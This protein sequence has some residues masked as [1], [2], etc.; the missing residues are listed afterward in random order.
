MITKIKNHTTAIKTKSVT[1]YK[2]VVTSASWKERRDDKIAV[3][4]I[5]Q[6]NLSFGL[7]CKKIQKNYSSLKHKHLIYTGMYICVHV[8]VHLCMCTCNMFKIYTRV[9]HKLKKYF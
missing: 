8:C 1:W 7:I 9:Q 6:N 4:E 3:D 2:M 5:Q